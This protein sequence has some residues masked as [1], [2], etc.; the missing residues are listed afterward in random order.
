MRKKKSPVPVA[1]GLLAAAVLVG[2]GGFALNRYAPT[3]EH[4]DKMEYYGLTDESQ[5][6]LVVDDQVLESRG[7]VENG[8]IYVDYRTAWDYFNS[9]F[10]WD[11]AQGQL[12]L[13]LPA[14][15]STWRADDGTGAVILGEDG[16]PYI[17]A[18][19]IRENSDIDMKFI[20]IPSGSWPAPDGRAYPY[21]GDAGCAGSLPGRAKKRDSNPGSEGDTVVFLEDLDGWT[22]VSTADGYVGYMQ[23]EDLTEGSG[24]AFSHTTEE[25]FLFQGA[26]SGVEGKINMGFHYIGSQDHNETLSQVIASAQGMNVIAPTWFSL[27]DSQGTLLSYGDRAYVDQAHSAGL[28]VWAV[29]GDV[30]GTDVSH[31]RSPGGYCQADVHCAAA[32]ADRGGN[33]P[34]RH[35]RGL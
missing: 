15:T 2:I 1:A 8:S 7:I 33:R 32:D 17:S 31:R 22:R 4:M 35:Q 23:S 21:D 29:I 12:M 30:N 20:R 19:C 24:E 26:A 10:Y 28:R 34:G 3:G 14:G 6:A 18:E 27:Q 16:T 25:R 5:A 11:A 13:T 9:G